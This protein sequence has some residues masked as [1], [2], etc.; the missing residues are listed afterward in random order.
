MNRGPALYRRARQLIP[1]GTQLLSKRPE[2]YLPEQWPA[3]YSRAE[4]AEVW[5]LDGRRYLDFSISGIGTCTLGYADPDVNAAVEA[6][7]RSGSMCTLNCPEE[8]ELAELFCELH[9]WAE[10]VRYARCGGESMAMAVRIA[11]AHTGRSKVAFC[12]YHGW[13]DWYLA[14]NLAENDSLGTKGLLLPGLAPA[15]VPPGLAGT[16][17]GFRHNRLDE[18]R[19]IVLRNRGEMAAIIAEPQRGEKPAPGFLEGLRELADEAGAVLIFDEITSGMRLATGGV[20]LLHGVAP[21]L[22]VFAK[23]ISNGFAMGAVIGRGRVMQAA[24]ETFISST[25]W[26]ER[27][28]PAAALATIRKHRALQV[29]ERLLAAGRRVQALWTDAAAGCGLPVRVGHPDMPPLSH[30]SVVCPEPRAAQTLH[31]QLM[32]ERGFLDNAGFY[33][34]WAHTDAVIDEYERALREVFPI[35]AAA[36]RADR[37]PALLRGPVGHSGFSRLT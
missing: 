9:P 13:S 28:G 26:T 19:E 15:G 21:D 34:T 35:L 14:A 23:G 4:G 25:Y 11:R 5:D 37:V 17:F 27:I 12:G 6:A 7:V 3:Y 30:F 32:L 20:H 1:G 16:A 29:P 24:Q 36:V 22:A 18:V 8:V 2:M 31:C 33:A 10:M